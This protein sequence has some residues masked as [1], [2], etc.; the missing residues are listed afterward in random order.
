MA[1]LIVVV[2]A[3]SF[4]FLLIINGVLWALDLLVATIKGTAG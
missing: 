2:L 4:S 3:G 1:D